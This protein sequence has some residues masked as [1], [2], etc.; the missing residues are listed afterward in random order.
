MSESADYTAE[1][2]IMQAANVSKMY[3]V[4][5]FY[6]KIFKIVKLLKERFQNIHLLFNKQIND[7]IK[8]NLNSTA[9]TQATNQLKSFDA[10]ESKFF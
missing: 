4:V 8:N 2:I 3:S 10:D 9:K 5:E 7:Y 1:F 6:P